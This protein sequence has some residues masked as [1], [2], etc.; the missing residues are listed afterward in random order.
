MAAVVNLGRVGKNFVEEEGELYNLHNHPG[1]TYA[2]TPKGFEAF[3]TEHLKDTDEDKKSI[4][5]F[6]PTSVC[7]ERIT[8][9]MI[10]QIVSPEFF[11]KFFKP[12]PTKSGLS[13][14]IPL[15]DVVLTDVKSTDEVGFGD[16]YHYSMCPYCLQIDKRE[17][18]CIYLTHEKPVGSDSELAPFCQKHLVVTELRN[19]YLNAGRAQDPGMPD[20]L[21][22]CAEC[23]SPCWHH[24]HFDNYADNF[25]IYP[26]FMPKLMPQKGV[27]KC[28]LKRGRQIL[29]ARMLAVRDIYADK[30][31]ELPKD[32]RKKA[33]LYADNAVNNA[34]LMARAEK[35]LKTHKWNTNVPTTK[36]YKNAAYG[37]T[38]PIPY[39]K[40]I[41]IN[42]HP[43]QYIPPEIVISNLAEN[44]IEQ[45]FVEAITNNYVGIVLHILRT[46]DIDVN[47]NLTEYWEGWTPL[48]V[49]AAANSVECIEILLKHGA[50]IN[51][52]SGPGFTPLLVAC[53]NGQ[54]NAAKFL[55]ENGA[56]VNLGRKSSE[57]S[58]HIEYPLHEAIKGGNLNIV[59]ELILR[60]AIMNP[61]NSETALSLSFMWGNIHIVDFLIEKGEE[62]NRIDV[63]GF[64]S[65][66]LAA[67]YGY[68]G[69]VDKIMRKLIKKN[70][71]T[72][73]KTDLELLINT[74][75]T[76]QF[77]LPLYIGFYTFKTVNPGMTPLMIAAKRKL[78]QTAVILCEWGAD[79]NLRDS[80]G[81][82]ADDYAT[83]D[84][85]L[86]K[87]IRET[88]P[89]KMQALES[90][91]A[92]F[93]KPQSKAAPAVKA[94]LAAR[95]PSFRKGGKKNRKRT[96]KN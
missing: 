4:P 8:P 2:I 42:K 35:I 53:Y 79:K 61:V 58:T 10:Q 37:Y 17:S 60:G 20:H 52:K 88:Q 73:K 33:A 38:G 29:I 93:K 71:D 7:T 46:T 78:S 40:P 63:N 30:T 24:R 72:G 6:A 45:S 89:V 91:L 76:K 15:H 82:S 22:F 47:K 87:R 48:G 86:R 56:D 5:C 12:V 57:N 55:M 70:I 44:K 9:P 28:P 85:N 69:I 21:E 31:I 62:L 1:E 23:G 92:S 49:A 26:H 54:E 83:D 14:I 74:Q 68:A 59:S 96:R 80:E 13:E 84:E 19:K 50:D 51:G 67:F 39:P 94:A 11:T 32:E 36:P 43:A 16:I 34:L 81:K 75:T 95:K 3:L 90:F 77:D 27:G 65:L 41:V 66:F 18:G 64:S 25:Y